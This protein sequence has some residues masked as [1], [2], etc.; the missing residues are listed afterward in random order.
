MARFE[1]L[2][3]VE[4]LRQA[5]RS[6]LLDRPAA[7]PDGGQDDYRGPIRRPSEATQHAP[8]VE[9]RHHE[10]EDNEIRVAGLDPLECLLSVAGGVDR[11][12]R[13]SE[14][15]GNDLADTI[16]VVNHQNPRAGTTYHDGATSSRGP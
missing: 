10:I 16:I 11:V 8:A 2:F 14:D 7:V 1:E 6:A 9:E 15:L 5:A 12:P 3:E 4:G 13:G